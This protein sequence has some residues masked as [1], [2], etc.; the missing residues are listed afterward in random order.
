MNSIRNFT[1]RRKMLNG[2]YNPQY[3]FKIKLSAQLNEMFV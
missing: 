1:S 2:Y 3:E